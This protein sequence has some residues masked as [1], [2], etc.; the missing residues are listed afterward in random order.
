MPS[1][2]EYLKKVVQYNSTSQSASAIDHTIKLNS[3]N[4]VRKAIKI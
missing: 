3:A 2:M 4:A 1:Y